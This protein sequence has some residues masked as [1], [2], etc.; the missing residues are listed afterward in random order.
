MSYNVLIVDDD[1]GIRDLL[2]GLLEE[3]GY[4]VATARNGR[5][6]LDILR[7]RAEL[8]PHVILLD[9]M[10]PV[11]DGYGVME[12]LGADAVLRDSHAIVVMSAAHRLSETAF[13]L[14][15]AQLPKPFAIDDVL[16]TVSSLTHQITPKGLA[17]DTHPQP[18]LV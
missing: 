4:N 5:E 1:T 7:A 14:A 2:E 12:V 13:P 10:M 6:A 16:E 15:K 11:L 9:L 3:E 8:G 18:P 17:G